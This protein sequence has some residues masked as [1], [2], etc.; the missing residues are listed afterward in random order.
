VWRRT[1][2]VWSRL[3]ELRVAPDFLRRQLWTKPTAIAVTLL[4]AV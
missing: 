2:G 4:I 1:N 3:Q